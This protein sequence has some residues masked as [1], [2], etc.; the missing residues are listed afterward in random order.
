M[1]DY[2]I[3]MYGLEACL[4]TF[5]NFFI[6]KNF[7]TEKNE[8]NIIRQSTGKQQILWRPLVAH[9]IEL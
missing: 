2:L 4:S 1:I 5:V 9:I 8:D 6:Q 3:C 7:L